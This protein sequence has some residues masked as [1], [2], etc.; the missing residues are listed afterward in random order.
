MTTPTPHQL[1]NL[2]IAGVNKAGTTS[3]FHYLAAHPQ[4]C[5]SVDKETC[6]FLPLLYGKPPAPISEYLSQFAH[7][8]SGAVCRMEATPGYFYGGGAIANAI[9]RLPT[10]AK[11]II[12][13]KDPVER[14]LSFYYRKRSTFQLPQEMTLRAYVDRCMNLGAGHLPE[15]KE[16]DYSGLYLGIYHLHMEEW[17]RVFGDRLQ[18]LFFDDLKKD[19]GKFVKNLA[20]WIG[21]DPQFYDDYNFEVRN[22]SQEFKNSLLQRVAVQLNSSGK[23][24]WRRHPESKQRLMKLYY[25]INGKPSSKP[26]SDDETIHWLHTFYRPHN[27]ELRKILLAHHITSLPGWLRDPVTD[28][29]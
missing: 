20:Q 16:I 12:I 25:F 7:C 22:Q 26:G 23:R 15:E 29:L 27:R 14:L 1:P 2:I 4:V 9:H 3:L 24:F 17:F 11:V 21:I 19:T 13:L 8:K 6:Y 5:A 10:E 18:L 28:L